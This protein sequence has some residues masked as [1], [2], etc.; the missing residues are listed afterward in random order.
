MIA[1]LV[2]LSAV[3]STHEIKGFPVVTRG[4]NTADALSVADLDHDKTVDIIVMTE[5][6][7]TVVDS[8]GAVRAGFPWLIPAVDGVRVASDH[9]AAVCDI[10]GDGQLELVFAASNQKLYALTR[11]GQPAPGFPVK[12]PGVPKGPVSCITIKRDLA[13]TT[14]DGNLVVVHGSGG[15]AK[16]IASIGKGAEGGVAIADLNGDHVVELITVGGDANLYVVD[17][18]GKV[19]KGFPAQLGF[20]ASNTPAVGDIDGDAKL[21]IVV[22]AQDYTIHAIGLDGKELAGF[23]VATK[24]R[25]YGGVA[26]ADIDDNDGL[27]VVAA[28]GDNSIYAVDGH[29]RAL[30]GFPVNTG[31]RIMT[32]PVVGDVDRDGLPDIVVVDQSGRLLVYGRD[33]KTPASIPPQ[34]I[35]DKGDVAPALADLD[36]DGALDILVGSRDSE[37]HAL[38]LTVPGQAIPKIQW[39]VAGHDAEHTGRV[40]QWAASF[41][42]LGFTAVTVRSA[43]GLKLR[44][45][46]ADLNGDPEGDTQVRWFVDGKA[47][48]DLDNQRVVPPGRM[49]KGQR[50]SFT[51]QDG[52]SFKSQSFAEGVA[53]ARS[54]EIIVENT[55]PKSAKIELAP[56]HPNTDATLEARL[57]T[58][59]VDADGDTL[60]YTYTW[61]RDGVPQTL[62]ADTT[63]IEPRLTTKNEDWRVVVVAHDGITFGEP[64]FATVTI[65]NT[66]PTAPELAL[67]PAA[68]RTSDPIAVTLVKKAR[69]EDGDVLRYAYRYRVNDVPLDVSENTTSL[70]ARLMRKGDTL[71]V[72]VTTHDDQIAGGKA[73]LSIKLANTAPE[74]PTVAVAP[75]VAKTDDNLTVALSNIIE[76]KDCDLITWRHQWFVDGLKVDAPLTVP[77]EK[78]KKGQR[79]KVVV[80]PFDGEAEGPSASAEVLIENTPPP[81]PQIAFK[82]V[83]V[84]EAEVVKPIVTTPKDAD[85]DALELK[86]RW[87]RNAQRAGFPPNKT[88]LAV[89][90]ANYGETW[91]VFVI[92]NDGEVDGPE[93]SLVFDV[94]MTEG[95]AKRA[96]SIVPNNRP[97]SAPTVVIGPPKAG[98][99]RDVTCDIVTNGEDPDSDQVSYRY[100]WFAGAKLSALAQM[101]L[102]RDA[103][104]APAALTSRGQS[105]VCEV[106]PFDGK[107]AGKT[108]RSAPLVIGNT[109]PTAPKVSIAP[110]KA[111]TT[112][113]LV[114]QLD[115]PG[116]DDDYDTLKYKYAWKV[117]GKTHAGTGNRIAASATHRGETWE[118]LVVAFDGDASSPTATASVVIDDAAPTPPKVV[119]LPEKPL[120]GT[121]LNCAVVEAGKDADDDKV[122][123]RLSWIRDGVDQ[124]FA[125]GSLFVPGRL[126]KARDIWQCV[127]IP[128]DGVL[129]GRAGSSPEVVIGENTAALESQKSEAARKRR[130]R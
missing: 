62:P 48:A 21:D 20:R 49:R 104:F 58:P 16:T 3:G 70:P 95:T 27:D 51:L 126:V 111:D 65:Q 40:G 76:D 106:T 39:P 125:P 103:T 97:P 79:W 10:D 68:P 93:A 1:A 120:A 89:G 63:K 41:R 18:T 129:D 82:K 112:H 2:L 113:E 52:A 75:A 26:L 13:L 99:D 32:A 67:E 46:Y 7:I 87:Q 11:F 119:V 66:P 80:T 91:T 28:S 73:E 105:W 17:I 42:D 30:K 24:Y 130:R 86:Y 60:T 25:I 6:G 5:P 45:R 4:A 98:G 69:D 102:G 81:L 128:F 15:T 36:G 90:D 35:T 12:L 92:A 57:V 9:P 64:G 101:P 47:Q 14:T 50:W 23:P 117:N 124:G 110:T 55:A 85:G 22:G 33:G 78:T 72:E 109:A 118:C 84:N 19:L 127:A 71:K 123:Y 114:C 100:A 61:I 43:D 94:G 59:A 29:G 121:D 8:K 56:V 53:I 96:S 54:P 116:V 107:V 77:A 83:P 34:R 88:E 31:V 74:T 108:V 37:L 122:D 38:A 44:Y 115:L